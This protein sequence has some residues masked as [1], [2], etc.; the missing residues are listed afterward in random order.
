MSSKRIIGTKYFT[1]AEKRNIA[2][3]FQN[4]EVKRTI[5]IYVLLSAVYLRL[6]GKPNTQWINLHDDFELNDCIG[7]HF[8]NATSFSIKPWVTTLELPFNEPLRLEHLA[9]SQCKKVFCLSSWV[10]DCQKVFLAQSPYRDEILPKL[11]LLHPSQKLNI[12]ESA[13]N[14]KSFTGTLRFIFVGRDF[15]RKGGY[16]CV[17]AF[18]EIL[19][20]GFDAELIIVSQLTTNDYPVP[21]SQENLDHAIKLIKDSQSKIKVFPEIS[22][23]E[24]LDLIANSHIGLLPTYNDSYGYSVLEFFSYGCPVITTNILA[25]PEINHP[26]R[27]WIINMPLTDNGEGLQ[28]IDRDSPDLNAKMSTLSTELLVEVCCSILADRSHLN[29]K[30]IAALRYIEQHHDPQKNIQALEKV[31]DSF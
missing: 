17:K 30:S 15:F 12:T 10:M 29:N 3:P 19:E 28:L 20:Q 11:E 1:Y 2:L 18:T 26:E 4:Y 5:D 24:V 14:N 7:F 23:Q 8:W 25:L 22:Q 9:R 31:Y 13:L 27:G 16:E 6:R 21:A